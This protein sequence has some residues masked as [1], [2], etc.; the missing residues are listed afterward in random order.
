[1]LAVDEFDRPVT[2]L[3]AQDFTL[4]DNGQP[5]TLATF[6]A[7]NGDQ[8]IA[9]PR[10]MLVLDA[11][12]SNSRSI[13]FEIKEI[14]KYLESNRGRLTYPTSIASLTASGFNSSR[15][16]IDG[17]ALSR[18]SKTLLKDI[19]PYECKGSSDQLANSQPLWGHGNTNYGLT[20]E[21]I[22]DGNCLNDRFTLS[23]TAL[24]NL[25][26]AQVNVPG[27]V[28]VIWIG[29]GW[30]LLTGPEFHTDTAEI[31][32]NFFDHF[33]LL[34]RTLREAQVTLDA[35]SS[36]DLLRKPELQSVQ[37]KSFAEGPHT[38]EEARA[39]DFALQAIA[40][41]S[42]GRI[43]ESNSIADQIARS[44]ADVQTYYALSFDS[45]PSSKPDEYHSLQVKANKPGV[46]VFTNT[47]YYG[48]P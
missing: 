37:L 38:E 11:L 21:K 12:N 16:S 25:A 47:L 40:T 20:L 24:S 48:E 23:L 39:S 1:V 30:P 41:Q 26:A 29:P 32:L 45:L 15:P 28:I 9:P 6:R 14:G 33:V 44:V 19:H 3:S 7:V 8:R 22:N 13:G 27:R 10:I 18:E 4:L 34:S 5:Q 2:G 36:P 17:S 46:R 43:T 35:V 42:G 31:R